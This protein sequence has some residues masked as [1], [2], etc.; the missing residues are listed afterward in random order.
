MSKSPEKT[1]FS[2]AYS[3]WFAEYEHERRRQKKRPGA[4][5]PDFPPPPTSPDEIAA[6]VATVGRQKTLSVLDI[7][8]T[9]LDRW[10]AGA[11]TIPRPCWLVLVMLAEGRLPGMSR[12]WQDFRFD[13]DRLCLIGTRLSYSAR[14]IAGWQYQLAHADA[15]AR[16][17]IELEKQ[18][19]HLLQ[20]GVFESANDPLIMATAGHCP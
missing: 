7:H 6:A 13:G 4:A 5:L 12:D 14:E 9:T 20:V 18:N 11:R 2:R 15:L 8:R 19:A 16:R 1:S 10:L 17:V 3:A